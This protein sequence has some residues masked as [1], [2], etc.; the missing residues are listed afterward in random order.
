MTFISIRDVRKQCH[1]T[2]AL[3]RDH[4]L[5]LVLAAGA[6]DPA[7]ADLALLGHVPAELV[8]VLPVD[9]VDLLLAEVTALATAGSSR[10]FSAPAAAV[11]ARLTISVSLRHR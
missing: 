9:F 11:A 1:L 3:H 10:P 6:R 4:D 8:E 2:G 7:R 5:L